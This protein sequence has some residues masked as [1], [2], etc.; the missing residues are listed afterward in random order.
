ME[1]DKAPDD[2]SESVN[3]AWKQYFTATGGR[4]TRWK[5]VT[6]GR[7]GDDSELIKHLCRLPL[8]EQSDGATAYRQNVI[9]ENLQREYQSNDIDIDMVAEVEAT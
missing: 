2:S 6:V 3:V 1:K 5:S 7:R 9:S 4:R 8:Q